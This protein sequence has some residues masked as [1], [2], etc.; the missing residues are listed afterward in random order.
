MGRG[1][2]EG[3]SER[4]FIWFHIV[5]EDSSGSTY[6]EPGSSYWRSD[7]REDEEVREE[8]T[9]ME[10]VVIGLGWALYSQTRQPPEPP[11]PS[12]PLPTPLP[13]EQHPSC[14]ISRHVASSKSSLHRRCITLVTDGLRALSLMTWITRSSLKIL[15]KLGLWHH[16][17]ETALAC[18]GSAGPMPLPRPQQPFLPTDQHT[19]IA[20]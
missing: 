19:Y 11:P 10:C 5:V 6:Q 16:E 14:S 8:A 1:A 7:E 20:W 12:P 9:G 4:Y 3:E 2:R 17:V 15:V 13:T 18:T